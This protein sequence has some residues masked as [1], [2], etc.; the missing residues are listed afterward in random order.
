[1]DLAS[2]FTDLS[3]ITA[4]ANIVIAAGTI[5][6]AFVAIFGRTFSRWFRRPKLKIIVDSNPPQCRKT[7][8]SNT[9]TGDK[10]ADC[11]YFRLWV[12]NNGNTSA[13]N[14][15]VFASELKKERA[16]GILESVKSFTPMNLKWSNIGGLY[17]PAVHPKAGKYCDC[18]H[19]VDPSERNLP[20]INMEND[21]RK[22]IPQDKSIL[23]F[24]TLV[25]ANTKGHL[26]PP[27]RYQLDI[28]VAAENA[29]AVNKR[30]EIK[31][32]GDWYSDEE[33]MLKDGVVF[34]SL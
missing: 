6:L 4:I 23:S 25:S 17:F 28:I 31:L 11:Y 30:I 2:I 7:F 9:K 26:Q 33:L 5:I 20:E 27:G 1:M 8:L 13:K 29:K 21:N 10:V 22:D 34:R 12:D 18:F 19:V 14:V 16:D 15:E 32:S 24:D 3:R